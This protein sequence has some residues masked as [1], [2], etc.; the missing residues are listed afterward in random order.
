MQRN[1]CI[2]RLCSLSEK[3]PQD[4]AESLRILVCLIGFFDSRTL[5]AEWEI[6][7]PNLA[8]AS[9]RSKHFVISTLFD[10]FCLSFYSFINFHMQASSMNFVE[11]L[12][13]LIEGR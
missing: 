5:I 6:C 1:N 9:S 7:L 10:F 8:F 11:A 2:A 12:H 3:A 4:L 13:Y